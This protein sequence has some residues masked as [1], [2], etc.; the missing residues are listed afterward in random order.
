MSNQYTIVT[1]FVQ[2]LVDTFCQLQ[3]HCV[4]HILTA[5]VYNLLARNVCNVLYLRYGVNQNLNANLTCT[6]RRTCSRCRNTCN[7]ATCCQKVVVKQNDIALADGIFVN[8]YGVNAIFL[9]VAF[10]DSLAREFAG[11]A[12]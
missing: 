7:C 3:P 4:V 10:L 6:I 8:L 12:A 11:F 5:N 2:Q 9:S 1:F